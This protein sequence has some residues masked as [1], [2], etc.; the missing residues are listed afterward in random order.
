MAEPIPG[1]VEASQAAALDIDH[2]VAHGSRV[3]DYLLGGTDNFEADREASRAMGAALEGGF[4]G[5]QSNCR[6]NRI[7]LGQAVRYLAGQKGVRQFLDIGP[8]VPT[9]NSTHEVAQTIAPESRIVY[10]DKDPIVWAHAHTLLHSTPEGHTEFLEEDLRNPESILEKAAG[11]LDLTQ[12]VALVLVAIY[13]MLPD[14]DDPY[15]INT[16]LLEG[17]APGSWVVLSHLTAD[18]HGE[19]WEEAVS[20]LSEA[21]REN[22]VNRT[23]AEF[24]R[25]VDGLELVPPGAAPIDDWLTDGPAPPPADI[26]P[27]LP[28][29]VAPDWVNPLWAAVGRK[30]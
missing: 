21:T 2:T 22:F 24:S 8:G 9:V 25:F 12:P 4:A 29:D 13:H 26:E 27:K 17:L 3:Y 11:T 1:D 20:R 15:R 6:T 14:D 30:V 10:V 16:A 7:F 19:P 28:D 18:F 5:I 23:H